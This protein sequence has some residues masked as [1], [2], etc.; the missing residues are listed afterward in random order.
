M[1]LRQRRSTMQRSLRRS[2]PSPIRMRATLHG[3]FAPLKCLSIRS[4]CG[5]VVP[6]TN[7]G[8]STISGTATAR[9]IFSISALIAW[10]VRSVRFI[11]QR[12]Q[13]RRS[14]SKPKQTCCDCAR[15]F[16]W[17]MQSYPPW[18]MGWLRMSNCL[19]S[20]PTYRRQQDRRPGNSAESISCSCRWVNSQH[21][22][23]VGRLLG[24]FGHNLGSS[25]HFSANVPYQ[26]LEVG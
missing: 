16:R 14:F 6:P 9:M 5:M 18:K 22:P 17:P 15:I 8:S 21:D 24:T 23:T 7:L 26:V 12:T 4:W 19:R 11:Y 20:W 3:T 25:D 2:S 1:Q 10:P 13:R